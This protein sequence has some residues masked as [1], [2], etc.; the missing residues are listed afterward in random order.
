VADQKKQKQKTRQVLFVECINQKVFRVSQLSG[1]VGL[2][3]RQSVGSWM[4]LLKT[5]A[6][7]ICC[8]GLPDC[9]LCSSAAVTESR[10]NQNPHFSFV[11]LRKCVQI[12]RGIVALHSLA[13]IFIN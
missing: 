12:G 2:A 7:F 5:V 11:L 3:N 10:L 13:Y 6:Y 8:W 9:Q 1:S 4:T